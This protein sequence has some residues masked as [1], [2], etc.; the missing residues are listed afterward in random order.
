MRPSRL[1][2]LLLLTI[3]SLPCAADS[4]PAAN[5]SYQGSAEDRAALQKTGEAI[6]KAFAQGDIEAVMAYHHPDVIKALASSNYLVGRNAVKAN[7]VQTFRTFR[8]EFEQSQ[9]E[10]TFF[11]GD[12][13]VEQSQFVIKG[14]PKDGG[15]PFVFRGRSQVVYV[16]YK[17]SPTGWASIRE[18]IQ[19][20]P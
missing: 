4:A 14:T 16:R 19:P 7:L 13:A 5:S 2:S 6:R 17:G 10:N 1:S 11:Q 15:T 3:L 18:L 8:L 9:V 12:T 20:A